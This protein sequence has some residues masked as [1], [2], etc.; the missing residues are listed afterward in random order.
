VVDAVFR[1][2]VKELCVWSE[3]A[4]QVNQSKRAV[5]QNVK[6]N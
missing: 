3:R 6:L 2:G 5:V 4:R 1:F